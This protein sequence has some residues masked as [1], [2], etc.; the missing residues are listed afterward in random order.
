MALPGVKG[1]PGAGKGKGGKPVALDQRAAIYLNLA[2]V[3]AELEHTPEATK[4]IQDA[5]AEFQ[6]STVSSQIIIVDAEISLKRGDVQSALVLAPPCPQPPSLP[7][8]P[9]P[10]PCASCDTRGQRG[11]LGEQDTRMA[12]GWP[13]WLDWWQ[14]PDGLG[15]DGLGG[16]GLGGWRI[17]VLLK[18]VSRG[19]PYYLKARVATASIH[20]NHRNNKKLYIRAYEDLVDAEKP[21]ISTVCMLADA[22]MRLQVPPLPRPAQLPRPPSLPKSCPHQ[23]RS[24]SD[25]V[26][27]GIGVPTT[28]VLPGDSTPLASGWRLP[29]INSESPHPKSQTHTPNPTP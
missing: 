13:A 29:T 17:Q 9:G 2:K 22:Y 14:V 12:R 5:R 26:C 21:T 4:I 27:R 16:D 23:S 18:S 1:G 7:P 15:G 20:L 24:F 19:D 25:A 3:H 28:R 11:S 6:G 8:A 10:T